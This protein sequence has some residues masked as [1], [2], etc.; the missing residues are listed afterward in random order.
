MKRYLDNSSWLYVSYKNFHYVSSFG[1]NFNVCSCVHFFDALLAFF[2]GFLFLFDDTLNNNSFINCLE[3]ILASVV[4]DRKE[5]F[6]F[7]QA[8]SSI[9]I[10]LLKFNFGNRSADMSLNVN[11]LK[12]EWFPWWLFGVRDWIKTKTASS[13]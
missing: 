12:W 3:R 2:F 5:V 13:C 6:H 1:I 11:F 9:V 4:R 8:L 10:C 7:Q